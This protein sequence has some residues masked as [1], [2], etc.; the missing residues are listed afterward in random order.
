MHL[1]VRANPPA[2]VLAGN[3]DGDG[4]SHPTPIAYIDG[5]PVTVSVQNVDGQQ[6]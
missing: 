5:V 4:T 2:T 1:G 6:R 3:H